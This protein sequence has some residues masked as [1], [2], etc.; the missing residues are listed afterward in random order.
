MGGATAAA[1]TCTWC[2]RP[3]KKCCG[4][5]VIGCDKCTYCKKEAAEYEAW[6]E[7]TGAARADGSGPEVR[8][9]GTCE[10]VETAEYGTGGRPGSTDIS[11]LFLAE[12]ENGGSEDQ[13]PAVPAK[14]E[15]CSYPI[16][17]EV[18]AQDEGTFE[19]RCQDCREMVNETKGT[20]VEPVTMAEESEP[21]AAAVVPMVTSEAEAEGATGTRGDGS[22]GAEKSALKPPRRNEWRKLKKRIDKDRSGSKASRGNWVETAEEA[23]G[24]K[25]H[26]IDQGGN[27]KRN[28]QAEGKG[29]AWHR[30]AKCQCASFSPT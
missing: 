5:C 26:M 24:V 3:E 29:Q 12:I 14:C 21:K 4:R 2:E 11:T 16:E 10:W 23:E 13:E 18:R 30:K 15:L 25:G 9:S 22:M 27:D 28:L 1:T 19:K 6:A 20:A 8:G 17:L 7:E